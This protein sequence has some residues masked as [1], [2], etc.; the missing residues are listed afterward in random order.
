MNEIVVEVINAVPEISVNLV[1]TVEIVAS[2]ES[3]TP[4]IVVEIIGTG[5]Q[6][7][8]GAS[9]EALTN[10]DIDDLLNNFV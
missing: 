6:G 1:D 10:Q 3:V 2:M 9:A 5:P 7:Q 8:P 4:E